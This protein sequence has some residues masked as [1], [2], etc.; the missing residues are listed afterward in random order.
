MLNVARPDSTLKDRLT[1][2]TPAKVAQITSVPEAEITE[3]GKAIAAAQD[4]IVVF[5]DERPYNVMV[6]GRYTDEGRA[7]PQACANLLIATGHVGKAN[8]GLLPLWPHNNT[9]GVY[10]MLSATGAQWTNADGLKVLYIVGSDPVG[11]AHGLPQAEFTV[12][13][14][15][16]LTKT[17][18]QADVVLP[19]LSFAERDGTFTNAERRVQRTYKGVSPTGQARADWEVF[20]ALADRLGLKWTYFTSEAVMEEIAANVP[21]YTGATYTTLAAVK[22]EWPPVGSNDLYFGGTA[23]D[24]R[25]GVGLKLPSAVEQDG[26]SAASWIEPPIL[27]GELIALR[28]R[29]LN[30]RGVLI[31]KSK[32]YQPRLFDAGIELN[33][34]D[35]ARLGIAGGDR[36]TLSIDGSASTFAARVDGRAPQGAALVPPDAPGG[37]AQIRTG[38]AELDHQEA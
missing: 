33:S 15:L 19:A 22:E 5:G 38:R 6:N 4:L 28:S 36:V 21:G 23:Y 1:N 2:Y 17:A 18:E 24:N 7:L 10:D 35:A 3:A 37:V 32:V 20:N 25:G 12:V 34:V 27:S 8:N 16:F 31:G 11:E 14:E 30:E 26:Q 13:Q 9:Q 29:R